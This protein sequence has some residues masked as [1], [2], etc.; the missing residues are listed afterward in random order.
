MATDPTDQTVDAR[1][2]Q[3]VAV[4]SHARVTIHNHPA[5][6][7][8]QVWNVP[9]R[10]VVFIGREAELAALRDALP[11]QPAAVHGM[12]GAGKTAVA[13]E[14]AH[15][16]ADDYDIGWW[17]SA[18]QPE[19][20]PGQLVVLAHAMGAAD[21]ADTTDVAIARLLGR[22]RH[23]DRWLLVFDNAENPAAVSA[24]LPAG[25]GHVLVTS[26]NPHWDRIGARIDVREFARAE[27]LDLIGRRGADLPPE[28]ADAVADAVGDLPLVVDQAAAL[29]ADTGWAAATYLDLLRERTDDLLSR[30]DE[31]AGY[32]ASVAAAWRVAFGQL[33][34]ANPA[35]VQLLTLVAWLGPEPVPLTVFTAP[36]KALPEALAA[37]VR[38]PL[39]WAD[40][41]AALRR[42]AVARVGTDTLTLHRVPAALLRAHSPVSEPDR[43]TWPVTALWLLCEAVPANPYDA[44][45]W[46][47]WQVL[48]P[49][50]VAVT[51]PDRQVTGAAWLLDR[52]ASYL[53]ATGQPWA[54]RL[55]HERAIRE[56]AQ[57]DDNALAFLGNY[58][59]VLFQLGEYERA[60]E[61]TE[62]ILDRRR[63][64]LGDDH[65]DTLHSAN[66]LAV[67]L[68]ATGEYARAR[69]L[70]L[71]TL[72]AILC[73]WVPITPT[74]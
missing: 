59:T 65:P 64:A 13:I 17:V 23:T 36:N 7:A 35:T 28:D 1:G 20:V 45:T 53:L 27:S 31:A 14:Y 43:L 21:P 72:A 61:L 5:R 56:T 70:D 55:F 37:A 58:C 32:P 39:A 44:A 30:R 9:A 11:T 38:D 69:D 16:H 47:S 4:G 29:L 48:L 6:P 40:L 34:E 18:A 25:A 15:R 68:R 63:Q 22:L 46:P 24:F 74:P 73:C 41:L 60:R 50:A 67:L 49:H 19:L 52:T 51:D 66:T 54:A 8:G 33:V 26:R 2:A 12:A 71:D 42:R 62:K 57:T 3:G 10:I